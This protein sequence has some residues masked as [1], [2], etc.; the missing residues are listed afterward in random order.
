M[1]FDL[2]RAEPGR[3]S[4]ITWLV[5]VPAVVF[6][7]LAVAVATDTRAVMRLDLDVAD[8]AYDVTAGHPGFVS[9]LDAVAVIFS[10]L[11]AG[12]VLAFI[13]AY[14]LW[15]RERAVAVWVVLSGVAV[16]GGNALLK[17]AFTRAWLETLG[18]PWACMDRLST[19]TSESSGFFRLTQNVWFS[20]SGVT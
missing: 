7:F 5:A 18:C 11:S 17:L 6:A 15:R 8:R 14:A 20:C 9:F 16:I 4:V 13:A 12:I 10:N 1:T 19:S 3:P 2:R